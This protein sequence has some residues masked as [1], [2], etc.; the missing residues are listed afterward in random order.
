MVH[1]QRNHQCMKKG[2]GENE[3]DEPH[4]PLG[5][6]CGNMSYY[7]NFKRAK[8]K[9]LYL[10]FLS[11]ISCC[12]VLAP[13]ILNSLGFEGEVLAHET[14]SNASLCSSVSNGTMCCDRS[15]FRSDVCV[16][17]GDIRTDSASSTITLYT[18]NDINEAIF[19]HEKIK[20]YTRK[21]ETSVMDTIDELE[22]VINKKQKKRQCDVRH[23]IPAVFF[24][25]GGYTGNLYHE[26]N[27]G[28][29]P[30][31]ITSH[32]FNKRVVFVILEYHN[33]WI[34]KYGNI[35]SQLSDFPPINFRDNK[36]H[37]FPEAIVGLRIHDELTVD[38]SL[39]EG[40]KNIRDFRELL[41]QA[42]WPRIRGLI[43]DEEREARGKMGKPQSLASSPPLQKVVAPKLVIIARN[44]SRTVTNEGPLVELGEEIGFRVEVLR[45]ARTSELAKVYRLLNSSDVMV[46]VHGAAMTH[47][48]FLRPKSV[49]IQ[50]IPLGTDWAAETYYGEP[51]KRL[52]LKYIGYK[53]LPGE[54]SLFDEYDEN[55]PVLRDPAAVNSKGW[56]VTKRIYLDHQNVRLN[57]G[58][59]RRRLIYAYYH[60][61]T[62]QM[63]G[64]IG[65][66]QSQ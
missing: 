46:G 36:T 38:S 39:M 35:L 37:C 5:L 27:D 4:H 44:G 52:G 18:T 17:K 11:L 16:M 26:F 2:G 48:L 60:S 50:I 51:A 34:T 30:L 32:H 57:L 21:W 61:I 41:D 20:P 6:V 31:Y 3:E 63:K 7:Y 65:L 29:L 12:F 28:I 40:N 19:S 22:L 47:F 43:Q 53:I 59:F 42:Y 14:D 33:W 49:F 8:P 1:Y 58:R 54:S 23:D 55:D 66:R 10:L 15:S 64:Q 25:T 56:E 24:S 9:L 45:P 62:N 13:Q